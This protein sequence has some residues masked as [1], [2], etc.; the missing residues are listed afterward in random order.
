MKT[1][2]LIL[3]LALAAVPFTALADDPASPPPPHPPMTQAQRQAMEDAMK[4]FRDKSMQLHQ[5]ARTQMLSALTPEH[6]QLLAQV[7][8]QLAVA[9]KPDR[10]AAAKQLDSALSSSEQQAILAA[11][12]TLRAGMKS[13]RDQMRAQME[14][15]FP[16]MRQ[17]RPG[18]P[19]ASEH[20]GMVS[21]EKEHANR[22]N[23]AGAVL[24]MTT[25]GGG[26]MQMHV[27]MMGRPPMKR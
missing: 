18:G 6:R 9:D 1:K 16:Q 19:G 23:D 26:E 25:L 2:A 27:M 15:Q 4:T 22:M 17:G 14:S 24:L 5:Q 13:L 20:G 7:A 21:S 8:G 11:A 10:D 3:A 12:G